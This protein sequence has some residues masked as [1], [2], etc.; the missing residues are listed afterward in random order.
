MVVAEGNGPVG[1]APCAAMTTAAAAAVVADVIAVVAAD[2]VAGVGCH[3]ELGHC[4]FVHCSQGIDGVDFRSRGLSQQNEKCIR[5]VN[6]P[7]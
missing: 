7:K 2:G 3:G 4:P 5:L 1:F 6:I